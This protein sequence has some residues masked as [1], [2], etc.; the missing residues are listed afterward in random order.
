MDAVVF[1]QVFGL[2]AL[3]ALL[4]SLSGR[5]VAA[6][7]P[8]SELLGYAGDMHLTGVPISDLVADPADRLDRFF[9]LCRRSRQFLP[10][11]LAYKHAAGSS[12]PCRSTLISP[13]TSSSAGAIL[14]RVFPKEAESTKFT[15]LNDRIEALHREILE[16]QRAQATLR[17]QREWL[18]TTLASIGDAVIA[19]GENGKIS[20]MNAVA[21]SLTGWSQSDAA[22]KPLDV[23]FD[24]VDEQTRH[25]VT[26]PSARCWRTAQSWDC[27]TIRY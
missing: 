11:A 16:R 2:L 14:C 27:P 23:I 8:F 26:T 7:R 9:R 18:R 17:A 5:V 19:T 1:Q 24:I 12:V 10:G 13:P 6:N 25:P 21:E 15:V 20:F 22:G 4:L 3:S